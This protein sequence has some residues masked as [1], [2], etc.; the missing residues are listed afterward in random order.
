MC[1]TSRLW[2]KVV[3]EMLSWRRKREAVS[4]ASKPKKKLLDIFHVLDM[5]GW[6]GYIRHERSSFFIFF[7]WDLDVI[8]IIFV[9]HT[10][11]KKKMEKIQFT[12]RFESASEKSCF[13]QEKEKI[14]Y[15]FPNFMSS[16]FHYF[17]VFSNSR[18][19]ICLIKMTAN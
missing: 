13:H 12:N 10:C 2:C 3:G 7:P 4:D 6:E 14:I 19:S 15:V 18:A 9:R 5:S 11:G 1:H 8:F 17:S 16:H